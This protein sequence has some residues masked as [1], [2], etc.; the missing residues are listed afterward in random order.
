MARL[1]RYILLIVLVLTAVIVPHLSTDTKAT[2]V[3]G[4]CVRSADT[5]MLGL[6][7]TWRAQNGLKALA[8]DQRLGAAAEHHSWDM[9]TTLTLSH[10]LSDG[11][12]WL[13][14]IINHGYT[15][16]GRG[17]NI[18]WGWWTAQDAFDFWKG[19]PSHNS[20]ML[21]SG[22]GAIGLSMVYDPNEPNGYFWTT[23]FGP[24]VMEAAKM[25]GVENTPTATPAPTI[26]P[27]PATVFP[28]PTPTPRP[29]KYGNS[30]K[31]R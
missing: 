17:E 12:T 11:T 6:I 28:S 24:S 5:Q 25:C 7:N 31:C 23:T 20:N 22:Y 14:N 16:T 2:D 29:C 18:A 10:T 1:T 27:P 3:S 4:Y 19:S 8:M 21:N 15:L 13:Q 26:L 9:A 30:W